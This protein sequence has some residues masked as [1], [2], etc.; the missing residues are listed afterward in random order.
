MARHD[1]N[2]V[3]R[4]R[5]EASKQ[6]GKIGG[7][8]MSMGSMLKKA[9]SMAAMYLGA[10]QI[11]RFGR[12]SLAEFGKQEQA[13][14][15]LANAY[16]LL[17]IEGAAPVKEMERFAEEIQKTT[18]YG[19]EMVLELATMGA[20]MGKLSG[21]ELQGATKAA[22][23]LA[24]A[25]KIDVVAAMRLVARARMGDTQTLARYGIKLKEGLSA[26][27]K[28]NEVVRIG[29]ENFRLVTDEA[30]DYVVA[31]EMMKNHIGDLKEKIG[32]ALVPTVLALTDR[33]KKLNME[34]VRSLVNFGK[35]T[36]AIGGAVLL[37]P[38]IVTAVLSIAK[39]I[40]A[41]AAMQAVSAALSG[42]AGWAALAVG[43][44]IAAAAV[45]GLE[46]A[47]SGLNETMKET[48]KIG[49]EGLKQQINE[50]QSSIAELEKDKK[51]WQ[52]YSQGGVTYKVKT[53]GMIEGLKGKAAELK[54]QLAGIEEVAR[55]AARAFGVDP[56][57][58]ENW[59]KSMVGD[60]KAAAEDSAW[61][62]IQDRIV[63]LRQ[64]I[65]DFGK[66]ENRLLIEDML[67]AGYS[68]QSIDMVKADQGRK[69]YQEQT[70][71][72]TGALRE[73]AKDLRR[74]AATFGKS[75]LESMIY[76]LKELG[77]TAAQLAPIIALARTVQGLQ[78]KAAAA[79]STSTPG[80]LAFQETRFL[81]F[82]AGAKFDYEQQTARNT[83]EQLALYRQTLAVQ[84]DTL[85][86][87]RRL[88]SG[89][90][91]QYGLTNF[92]P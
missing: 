88:Q 7:S 66:S 73:A 30:S 21:K 65:M 6:F 26:Q 32:E 92:T 27:Q 86:E 55:G 58:Q 18:R 71:K 62:K 60:V 15:G 83:K 68:E 20:T 23:G 35:W 13:V 42:P 50:I 56:N 85:R 82:S 11:L 28:Y 2:V 54:K 48:A 72:I 10:R 8:A 24:K 49:A 5:D 75:A 57:W 40:K 16:R 17:G 37:A 52:V 63:A 79:T 45:K 14:N 31:I 12:E 53:Q 4:A 89:G 47:F 87:I 38:K 29:A 34:H 51:K 41:L 78:D 90:G 43:T 19:D 1:V 25:Y 59:L 91:Q 67:Q 36:I 84:R 44:V 77:A 33:I 70:M 69:S 80:K 46:A 64:S 74:Q 22:M 76:D 39:A 3:V 81:T 9:A 61:K